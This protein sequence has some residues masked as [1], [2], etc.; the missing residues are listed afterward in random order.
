MN[1]LLV[2][3]APHAPLDPVLILYWVVHPDC[4][5]VALT[6]MLFTV[7]LAIVRCAGGSGFGLLGDVQAD[8]T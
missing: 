1:V 4:A 7:V 3:H 2:C 6:V 5:A 8:V